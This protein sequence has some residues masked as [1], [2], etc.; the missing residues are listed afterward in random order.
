MLEIPDLPKSPYLIY[1]TQFDDDEDDVIMTMKTTSSFSLQPTREVS[2]LFIQVVA[3]RT[4]LATLG[5]LI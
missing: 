4:V 5:N 2:P 1:L 3:V